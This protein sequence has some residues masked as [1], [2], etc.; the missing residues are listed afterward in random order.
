MRRHDIDW[1]RILLFGKRFRWPAVT[2]ESGP[3]MLV[4]TT[5]TGGNDEFGERGNRIWD[6]REWA[7]SW[8]AWKSR[9]MRA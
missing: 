9:P 6:T 5:E 4:P 3:T 2:P 7:T 8:F 1:L